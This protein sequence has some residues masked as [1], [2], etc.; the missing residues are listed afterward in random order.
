MKN[1]FLRQFMTFLIV[2]SG[3]GCEFVF[4]NFGT[5]DDDLYPIF[6]S[7]QIPSTWAGGSDCLQLVKWLAYLNFA[8]GF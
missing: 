6:I 3:E 1:V 2:P 5:V 4:S 7:C 8:K